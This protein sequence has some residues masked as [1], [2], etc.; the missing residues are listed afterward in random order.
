MEISFGLVESRSA[1]TSPCKDIGEAQKKLLNNL[2]DEEEKP[3]QLSHSLSRKPRIVQRLENGKAGVERK[4]KGRKSEEEG[5]IFSMLWVPRSS[6]HIDDDV[7]F[8]KCFQLYK[9]C[10]RWCFFGQKWNYRRRSKNDKKVSRQ[11]ERFLIFSFFSYQKVIDSEGF[12]IRNYKFYD[13]WVFLILPK[14]KKIS[15]NF[16]NRRSLKKC[17]SKSF[18][19]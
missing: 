18:T 14:S 13:F 16:K 9:K 7:H 8:N 19:M 1:G 4:A 5:R 3:F 15:W 17:K 10:C 6:P 11:S 12:A 2:Y